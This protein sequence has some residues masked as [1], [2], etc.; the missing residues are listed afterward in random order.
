MLAIKLTAPQSRG[1]S[2]SGRQGAAENSL[3]RKSQARTKPGEG[4]SIPWILP[5]NGISDDI[6][7]LNA[8]CL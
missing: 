1:N 2:V 3:A 4:R 8:S 5:S 7:I 6:P